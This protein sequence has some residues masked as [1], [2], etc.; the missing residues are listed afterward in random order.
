MQVI[1]PGHDYNLATLDGDGSSVRLTFVKREGP[2]FPGNIGCYPGRYKYT[3]LIQCVLRWFWRERLTGI[4]CLISAIP[5]VASGHDQARVSDALAINYKAES[6]PMLDVEYIQIR[7]RARSKNIKR[8]VCYGVDLPLSLD[9]ISGTY[10]RTKGNTRADDPSAR[11]FTVGLIGKA[12]H[13]NVTATYHVTEHFEIQRRGLATIHKLEGYENLIAY[14]QWPGKSSFRNGKPCALVV[15]RDINARVQ[16]LLSLL[17]RLIHGFSHPV[18]IPNQ[19]VSFIGGIPPAIPHLSKLAIHRFELT[20]GSMILSPGG[21]S[22]NQGQDVNWRYMLAAPLFKR[23]QAWSC[24]L[25]G[26]GFIFFSIALANS[27]RDIDDHGWMFV[28]LLIGSATACFFFGGHLI[29]VYV[30]FVT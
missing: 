30:R 3:S 4:I 22:D 28:F 8:T 7:N 13:V 6:G 19:S 17:Y 24:L 11:V 16:S 9:N 15:T 5:A 12:D 14:G 29:G 20:L 23:F 18:Y 1:D 21:H 2:G 26:T 25:A 27:L 10:L